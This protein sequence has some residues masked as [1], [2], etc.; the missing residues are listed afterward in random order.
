VPLTM[1]GQDDDLTHIV[2]MS[3]ALDAG[4]SVCASC[5]RA[6]T[7]ISEIPRQAPF[8]RKIINKERF[9][10]ESG[11]IS[12]N[13]GRATKVK[14]RGNATADHVTGHPYASNSHKAWSSREFFRPSLLTCIAEG[15]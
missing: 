10:F 2:S 6:A 7:A 11:V 1:H 15:F 13:Y 12:L 9:Q 14:D 5:N 3:V 8:G 4:S